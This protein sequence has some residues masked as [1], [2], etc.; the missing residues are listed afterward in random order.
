[1]KK[2]AIVTGA[3]GNLG[4]AVVKQLL[5]D[6]FLVAG[7][8]LPKESL[9]EFNIETVNFEEFVLDVTDPGAVEHFVEDLAKKYGTLDR[10]ALLVGGFAMGDLQNTT[11]RDIQ[12]M[13]R[14]NF[15]SAFVSAKYIYGQ[16]AKQLEGGKIVLVG[17]RPALDAAAGK[18]VFAYT[19]SKSLIFQLA[20]LLNASGQQKGVHTSVIVPSII[21]TP[22]NREGMPKANFDDW[23]KPEEI[24][25]VISFLFSEKGS[26]LRETVV[27]I[28][29]NS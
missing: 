9:D 2:T 6:G 22:P 13:F 11:L 24:A 3:A 1:M 12:S 27:K 14:L 18:N 19:L 7:T 15:E 4:K 29:G 16:M 5:E 17:A 26:K 28:Y 10:A 25:G 20:D 21:D 8:R 23:V